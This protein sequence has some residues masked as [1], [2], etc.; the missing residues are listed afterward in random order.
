[1]TLTVFQSLGRR[2]QFERRTEEGRKLKGVEVIAWMGLSRQEE[3]EQAVS[4]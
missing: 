1:M 3:E 2:Q 4:N